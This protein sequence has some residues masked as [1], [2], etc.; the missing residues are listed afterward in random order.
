MPFYFLW[1]CFSTA[2]R[3]GKSKNRPWAS[4]V[5]VAREMAEGTTMV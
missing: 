1:S 2:I 4:M 5:E 3:E